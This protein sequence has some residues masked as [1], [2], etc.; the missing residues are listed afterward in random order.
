[1]CDGWCFKSHPPTRSN[2]SA[3]PFDGLENYFLEYTIF[4]YKKVSEKYVFPISS[5]QKAMLSAIIHFIQVVQVSHPRRK[6]KKKTKR[7][8][9]VDIK[10]CFN[11]LGN[12]YF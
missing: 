1:M 9:F 12:P 5:K 2:T 6:Q 3:G 11:Y 8:T 4:R 7:F 10:C